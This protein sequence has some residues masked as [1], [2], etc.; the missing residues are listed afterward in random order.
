M[1]TINEILPIAGWSAYAVEYT[2]NTLS[3]KYKFEDVSYLLCPKTR[4]A[5]LSPHQSYYLRIRDLPVG[6]KQTILEIEVVECWCYVC[7]KFHSARPDEL[8]Y[9]MAMTW[10]LMWQLCWLVKEGSV[11]DIAKQYKLSASS[12]RRADKAVLQL[13][14]YNVVLHLMT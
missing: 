2:K 5:T 8:H 11:T 14:D 12:V 9:S 6:E 4:K 3:I 10:Q 7:N 13:I 1:K